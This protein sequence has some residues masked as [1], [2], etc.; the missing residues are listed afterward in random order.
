MRLG[1]PSC[2]GSPSHADWTGCA[3]WIGSAVS[4]ARAC[5]LAALDQ[6]PAAERCKL[7]GKRERFF[8]SFGASSF[9]AVVTCQRRVLAFEPTFLNPHATNYLLAA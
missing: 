5:S 4:R 7:V 2:S 8:S 1:R 9:R 6:L 3:G